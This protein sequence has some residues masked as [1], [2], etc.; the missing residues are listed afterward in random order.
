MVKR[1]SESIRKPDYRGCPF[2][3]TL[4]KFPDTAHLGHQAA[5]KCRIEKE[6]TIAQIARLAGARNPEALA[7]QLEM[8]YSGAFVE[9]YLHKPDSDSDNFYNAA[10]LLIQA[11][12]TEVDKQI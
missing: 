8:L 1:L 10:M 11:Q 4:L 6:G 7:A 5:L 9:N 3:N 2:T 12:L